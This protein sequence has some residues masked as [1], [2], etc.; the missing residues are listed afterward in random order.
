MT[1]TLSASLVL[2]QRELIRF[3]RQ[4][5]RV[6]GSLVTPL[7]FWVFI[8][9]G[10]GHS[11]AGT[12]GQAVGQASQGY[13][14]YF[15][16][17]TILLSLLFT[18]IFSTISI[19]EDRREGFLQGVLVA[20]V[21][22]LAIVGGKVLGGAMMATGQGVILV[23]LGWASGVIHLSAVLFLASIGVMFIASVGLTALGLFI[24]WRLTSTQGF[25]VIMNIFLMP[26]WLLSGA[27]FPI[28]DDTPRLFAA[29]MLVNPLTYALA[30]LRR[31]LGDAGP[32]WPSHLNGPVVSLAIMSIA[33]AAMVAAAAWIA[34]G[35]SAADAA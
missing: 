16:P 15:F 10:M 32:V 23:L 34:Q 26:M 24:A 3:V 11:F 20:P 8:G 9:F 12:P 29:V 17:G 28:R 22:R 30:S 21:G 4:R 18:A 5:N 27:L 19:I 13:T 1:Q 7:V 35:R 14:T 6:I 25:H 33:T 31:V 2:C